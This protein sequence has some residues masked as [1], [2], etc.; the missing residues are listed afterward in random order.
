MA[1]VLRTSWA[2]DEIGLDAIMSPPETKP[3]DPVDPALFRSKLFAIPSP[4]VALWSYERLLHAWPFHVSSALYDAPLSADDHDPSCL[5][6]LIPLVLQ[7]DI[8]QKTCSLAQCT[9]AET[10]QKCLAKAVVS[11]VA[12]LVLASCGMHTTWHRFR[13][14]RTPVPSAIRFEDT[15]P[16]E[17]HDGYSMDG[18]VDGNRSFVTTCVVAPNSSVAVSPVSSSSEQTS[19]RRVLVLRRVCGDRTVLPGCGAVHLRIK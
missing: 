2:Y 12:V 4:G 9:I 1:N 3:V 5:Q 13:V 8:S 11:C 17:C 19:C 6:V 15:V 10:N 18:I 7:R 14:L 16:Y